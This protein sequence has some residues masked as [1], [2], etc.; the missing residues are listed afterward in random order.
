MSK[1]EKPKKKEQKETAMS[2]AYRKAIL[3][4]GNKKG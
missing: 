4:K 2:I 1:K 3:D